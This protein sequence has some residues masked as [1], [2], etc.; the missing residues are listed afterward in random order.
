MWKEIINSLKM[1]RQFFT[2]FLSALFILSC[3]DSPRQNKPPQSKIETTRMAENKPPGNFSDTL[4][5]NSPA[6]VFY[7][8]DSLQLEKIKLVTNAS[9][10]EGSMHEYFYLMRNAHFVIKRDAPQ[11]KIIEAKNVRY[12]L[13][14]RGNKKMYCIDLDT[15]YDPYGLFVFNSKNSPWILDMANI[16]SE[17]GFYFSK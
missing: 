1:K 3:S 5:I 6:A 13:F 4:I 14:M 8:P 16:E 7:Y 11:L 15:K 2:F 9:V 17:L 10:Y 12:L